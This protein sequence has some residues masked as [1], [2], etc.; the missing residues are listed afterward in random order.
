MTQYI[1]VFTTTEKKED[2]EKITKIILERRLAACV[3]ILGPITSKYWW[4]GKIETTEEWVCIIKSRK[5]LYKELE[6]AIKEIHAYENPEIIALPIETGRKEYLN[7][8]NKELK[9]K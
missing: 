6:Q 9:K 2:T 4:K 3:Q 5:N 1:Q 7:W 8:L